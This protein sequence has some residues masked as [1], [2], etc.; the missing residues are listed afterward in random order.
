MQ[1]KLDLIKKLGDW[2]N[3]RLTE[4][5]LEIW[6]QQIKEI[7][8]E[9]LS[10]IVNSVIASQRVFPTPQEVQSMY[11]DWLAAHPNKIEHRYV[12]D[13]TTCGGNGFIIAQKWSDFYKDWVDVI[14]TCRFCNKR[15]KY[16][17]LGDLT[18]I[19]QTPGFRLKPK[20]IRRQIQKLTSKQ[21]EH[22]LEKMFDVPF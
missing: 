4:K 2:F 21:I 5:Q 20:E 18:M 10:D 3:K 14:F 12:E 17:P 11:Q 19:Q 8:L 16:G 22:E 13:C 1:A 9:P 7:P 6:A 15:P